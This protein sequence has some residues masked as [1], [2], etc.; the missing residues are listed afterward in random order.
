MKG[1][2]LSRV[3]TLSYQAF[4]AFRKWGKD[5]SL[6]ELPLDSDTSVYQGDYK[7]T[8]IKYAQ[9]LANDV[10]ADAEDDEEQDEAEDEESDCDWEDL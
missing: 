3:I 10:V 9:Q 8:R 5:L 6:K 1:H 4:R 7:R 2:L